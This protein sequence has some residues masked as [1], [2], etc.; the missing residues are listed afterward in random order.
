Q[1]QIDGVYLFNFFT[2]REG[3]AE[4][5]FDGIKEIG[6]PMA[7]GQPVLLVANK[8][9]NTLSFVNPKTR[10]VDTTISTGLNPHEIVLT[11]DHRYA[12]LSNY[13]PPGNT[14][15]VIDLAKRQHVKQIS[16]G[17]YG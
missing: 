7:S 3:N 5:P 16:T 4:P 8:H 12:Y 17:E 15:T 14:I 13:A 9:S 1:Q 6:L 10:N 2:T 11:P